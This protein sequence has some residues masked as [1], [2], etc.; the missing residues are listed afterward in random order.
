[1]IRLHYRIQVATAA[2][3]GSVAPAGRVTCEEQGEILR[4]TLAENGREPP[5]VEVDDEGYAE[6]VKE[7]VRSLLESVED[8]KRLFEVGMRAATCEEQHRIALRACRDL[9]CGMWGGGRRWGFFDGRA[10]HF[11]ARLCL[12]GG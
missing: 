3:F 4:E 5:P 1:M 10:A 9:A 6:R 2:R 11:V 8:P 12:I 7:H